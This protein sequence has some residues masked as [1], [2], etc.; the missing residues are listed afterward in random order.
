MWAI[1]IYNLIVVQIKIEIVSETFYALNGWVVP[2]ARNKLVQNTKHFTKSPSQ[3]IIVFYL[4]VNIISTLFSATCQPANAVNI[5]YPR[6]IKE[7]YATKLYPL[8]I[9]T[10]KI[11]L[12]LHLNI[13]SRIGFKEGILLGTN[14]IN[15]KIS[16]TFCFIVLIYKCTNLL[17]E[18][19]AVCRVYIFSCT[20]NC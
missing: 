12:L 19:M 3:A 10:P 16:I 6:V 4:S 1:L 17:Y 15:N 20:A 5:R 2:T 7:L 11:L 14:V 13:V 9:D 18:I 8:Y